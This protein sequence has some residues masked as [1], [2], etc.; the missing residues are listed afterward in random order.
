MKGNDVSENYQNDCLKVVI[1][2]AIFFELTSLFLGLKNREQITAFQDT[3][4]VKSREDTIM[5]S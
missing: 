2:L 4:K 5:I 3:K 1:A